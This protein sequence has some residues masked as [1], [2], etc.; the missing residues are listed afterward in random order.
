M[1]AANNA[2]VGSPSTAGTRV[3][4]RATVSDT[5]PAPAGT[6]K[7]AFSPSLYRSSGG[8]TQSNVAL[9]AGLA[10][11]SAHGPLASGSYSFKAHYN[12]DTFYRSEEPRG[13]TL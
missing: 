12:G 13:G 1:R 7:L 5:G 2:P 8:V 10:D 9:T 4:G 3:H 11:S 6:R